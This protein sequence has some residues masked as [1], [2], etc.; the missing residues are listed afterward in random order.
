MFFRLFTIFFQTQEI[1]IIMKAI[2]KKVIKLPPFRIL[3][4]DKLIKSSVL[5]K[6][7]V[8]PFRMYLAQQRYNLKS[9][10]HANVY[11]NEI[12]ALKDEGIV[13]IENFLQEDQFDVLE[14]ECRKILQNEKSGTIRQDGA[15]TI[16]MKRLLNL[17]K[18]DYPE[19]FKFLENEKL[20]AL[21]EAA[22]KRR[23]DFDKG[24]VALLLQY[25]EQGY[26]KHLRDPETELHADTFFNTHK[27]WL[28]MN[29]V[30]MK[31]APFV[32]VKGSHKVKGA[33]R[34]KLAYDYSNGAI[35][36]SDRGGS[37][38]VGAEELKEYNLER[39]V[40]TCKKNTLVI[41]NTMGYHCRE[42]GEGGNDRL[43]IAVSARFNPFF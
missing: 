43:T 25:L 4:K 35:V 38:R 15:N 42:E 26:D 39:T 14:K 16:H 8:Q 12:T 10:P 20:R 7:G 27:A 18:S 2:A 32:F 21:F 24:K 22:E 29:D 9:T 37:R 1:I 31:N 19:V 28:Y 13:V 11:E 41:A 3:S 36:G 34:Y 17:D 23:L 30:E 40:Y 33:N 5:N 6:I